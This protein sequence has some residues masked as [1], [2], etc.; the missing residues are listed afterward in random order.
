MEE[1]AAAEGELK[2]FKEAAI[3]AAGKGSLGADELTKLA[4]ENSERFTPKRSKT[5]ERKP[6][7]FFAGCHPK[8]YTRNKMRSKVIWDGIC[9]ELERA[10]QQGI[11][12]EKATVS[13]HTH[14]RPLG[15]PAGHA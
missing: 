6:G 1:K 13:K 3:R 14:P 5:P 10:T 9:G 12:L 4:E 2:G 15:M 8:G 7:G 11:E